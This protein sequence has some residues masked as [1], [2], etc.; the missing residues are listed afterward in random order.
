MSNQ[1]VQDSLAQSSLPSSSASFNHH[2]QNDASSSSS[3]SPSATATNSAS[4]TAAAMP[5]IQVANENLDD[6]VAPT[7]KDNASLSEPDTPS[8]AAEVVSASSQTKAGDLGE[9]VTLEVKN[10]SGASNLPPPI[11]AVFGDIAVAGSATDAVNATG[12]LDLS[13]LGAI[14]EQQKQPDQL[15]SNNDNLDASALELNIPQPNLPS[16]SEE[17]IAI[18]EAT[19]PE[20]ATSK[21][22]ISPAVAETNSPDPHTTGDNGSKLPSLEEIGNLV[23]SNAVTN[24]TAISASNPSVTSNSS[25][26]PPTIDTSAATFTSNSGSSQSNNQSTPDTTSPS[27]SSTTT[28]DSPATAVNTPTGGS[29]APADA[30][31]N[32]EL[33][34]FLTD[35]QSQLSTKEQTNLDTSISS[36]SSAPEASSAIVSETKPV[37]PPEKVLDTLVAPTTS[38]QSSTSEFVM[39][40]DDLDDI[41]PIKI[42]DQQLEKLKLETAQLQIKNTKLQK[43]S[44]TLKKEIEQKQYSA[45]VID[46]SINTNNARIAECEQQ[47]TDLTS[48]RSKIV[49]S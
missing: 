28:Y 47:Q 5:K 21:E 29:S 10:A 48:A 45:Q 46:Y 36:S 25:T 38:S 43:A 2:Q 7:I 4:I 8:N 1:P 49:G 35:N 19:S 18:P 17:E 23:A 41:S 44:T 26:P 34:S 20:L 6:I 13:T 22:T 30:S 12:D 27:S 11:P 42:I 9:K 40:N 15:L 31:I 3:T 14:K 16:A 24:D 37:T 32:V 33:P 39:G